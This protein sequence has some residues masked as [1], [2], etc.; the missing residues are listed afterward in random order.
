MARQDNNTSLA[1]AT[2]LKQHLATDAKHIVHFIDTSNSGLK[3]CLMRK[4][5]TGA[6]YYSGGAVVEDYEEDVNIIIPCN[7]IVVWIRA[8]LL[9]GG[10]QQKNGDTSISGSSRSRGSNGLVSLSSSGCGLPAVAKTCLTLEDCTG[11]ADT[12]K[13]HC[14]L[15]LFERMQDEDVLF[16]YGWDTTSGGATLANITMGA[17]GL[18]CALDY[19]KNVVLEAK[20]TLLGNSQSRTPLGIGGGGRF[21]SRK[22]RNH[23]QH[24]EQDLLCVK[25]AVR[26]TALK[27]LAP[28]PYTP[29]EALHIATQLS[30]AASPPK[31]EHTTWGVNNRATGG[32]K[33]STAMDVACRILAAPSLYSVWIESLEQQEEEVFEEDDLDD[34]VEGGVQ[35]EQVEEIA[36]E[37]PQIAPAGPQGELMSEEQPQMEDFDDAEPEPAVAAQ[38][39]VAKEQDNEVI[40]LGDTDDEVEVPNETSAELDVASPEEGDDSDQT[41]S[42]GSEADQLQ[43]YTGEGD[44]ASFG[45]PQEDETY[46]RHYHQ[47]PGNYSGSDDYSAEDDEE[48]DRHLAYEGQYD[49]DEGRGESEDEEGHAP[50]RPQGEENECVELLESSEEEEEVEQQEESGEERNETD[51]LNDKV[52]QYITEHDDNNDQSAL[53]EAEAASANE[54]EER[55]NNEARILSE[56]VHDY[57]LARQVGHLEDPGQDEQEEDEGDDTLQIPL[58]VDGE[59]DQEERE[60]QEVASEGAQESDAGR[61]VDLIPP[62]LLLH[63]LHILTSFFVEFA[64]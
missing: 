31:L 35:E 16:E 10:E 2:L 49:E 47:F 26:R 54:S 17:I 29:H 23:Q 50:A 39:P 37:Q 55:Q 9:A 48:E 15:L 36:V 51:I 1:A 32:S 18:Q 59:S 21:S 22:S 8:C 40:D 19:L 57:T 24:A 6:A 44:D 60:E 28:R 12:T 64:I 38:E 58:P 52:D 63:L 56:A 20:E 42:I 45:V 14:W 30:D 46:P 34:A 5:F 7:P 3:Q 13:Q 33:G 41:K 53:A 27:I 11:I 43:A 4:K 62:D 25:D 61:Y